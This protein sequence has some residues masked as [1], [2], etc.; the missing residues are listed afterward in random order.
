MSVKPSSLILPSLCNSQP[1]SSHYSYPALPPVSSGSA[2]PFPAKAKCCVSLSVSHSCNLTTCPADS[3]SS[4]SHWPLLPGTPIGY[5]ISRLL[6]GHGSECLVR[7]I[8]SDFSHFSLSHTAK[9]S[10]HPTQ[11]YRTYLSDVY[12]LIRGR[13]YPS[14]FSHR[15][16]FNLRVSSCF[17][18]C[19][20]F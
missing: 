19:N 16:F 2:Y 10:S 17:V 14:L 6:S 1:Y 8:Q 9:N 3:N 5:S 11:R 15:N 18:P 20:N 13:L 4:F 7:F 12:D